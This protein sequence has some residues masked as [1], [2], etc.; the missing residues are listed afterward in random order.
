MKVIFVC[1]GNTCRSP[2]AEGYLPPFALPFLE[3]ETRGLFADGSPVSKNSADAMLEMGIDISNHISKQF[4]QDDLGADMIICM[5]ESHRETL[6]KAGAD[7]NRV[8]VL[9]DGIYD[10]FGGDIHTYRICRDQIT[11]NIDSLIFGGTFTD[12]QIKEAEYSHIKGIENLEKECF[13]EPWSINALE[14]SFAAGTRF[15]TAVSSDGRVIGY[16]GISTILDE[17]Y[18]TNIAV[19][20]SHRKTGVGTLLIKRIF[21]FAR[22]QGL[23]FVSLEVRA[24]NQNAISLYEKH[25]FCREGERRDFYTNPKENAIIMTRR[26]N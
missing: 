25:G 8:L 24:S 13:S 19:T 4:S 9:G 12:F 26:F 2:M 15:F 11:N 3:V 18:I 21:A 7:I 1:T 17:G 6:I 16:I 5:S 20:K 10:P 22:K 23:A 14:E